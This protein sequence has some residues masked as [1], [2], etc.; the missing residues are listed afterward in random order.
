VVD[1]IVDGRLEQESALD[2]IPQHQL[3]ELCMELRICQQPVQQKHEPIKITC[4]FVGE[5]CIEPSDDTDNKF[6][7]LRRAHS[8]REL[9]A[10]SLPDSRPNRSLIPD[11]IAMNFAYIACIIP[12]TTALSLPSGDA[13]FLINW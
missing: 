13:P 8:V 12:R 9:V 3:D 6:D 1:E 5:G 11:R 2:D 7:D 4:V 10:E